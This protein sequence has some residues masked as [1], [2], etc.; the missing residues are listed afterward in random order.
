MKKIELTTMPCVAFAHSFSAEKY[1][2]AFCKSNKAIEI[3]YLA[4]GEMTI[5]TNG[6]KQLA[7]QG[8]ILCVFHNSDTKVYAPSFHCHHTVNATVEWR[9]SL[10]DGWLLPPVTKANPVTQKIEKLI[11][12]FIY[13]SYEFEHRQTQASLNFMKILSLVDE[14]NR[15]E[16]SRKSEGELLAFRAKQYV[17]EHIDQPIVQSD[18]AAFLNITPQYLC[19]VFKQSEGISF[20]RYVNTTKLRGVKAMIDKEN[21]KLYEA[22][23]MFGYSDPNYVSALYKKI[24]GVNIAEHNTITYQK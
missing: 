2:N 21:I 5:Q 4:Q 8:D 18:V 15:I 3:S 11:D 13:Q 12:A 14:T 22:S 20:I 9:T 6:E 24:F 19:S 16:Q 7:K 10:T 17:H 1:Q 23:R